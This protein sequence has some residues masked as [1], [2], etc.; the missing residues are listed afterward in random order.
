M[1]YAFTQ[2]LYCAHLC[3]PL[4]SFAH[5]WTPLYTFAHLCTPMHTFAHA[6]EYSD[7]LQLYTL[8]IWMSMCLLMEHLCTSLHMYPDVWQLK[9]TLCMYLLYCA[10]TSAQVPRCFPGY[11]YSCAPLH[12]S[13]CTHLNTYIPNVFLRYLQLQVYTYI[14][15]HSIAQV[16]HAMWYIHKMVLSIPFH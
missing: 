9:D 4:D 8:Y 12:T 6:Y 15:T 14:C 16:Y 5:L 10:R 3:T 7:V 2:F 13:N 11:R 1:C